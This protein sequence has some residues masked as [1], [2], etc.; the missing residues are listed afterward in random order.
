MEREKHLLSPSS[1]SHKCY[2]IV[3]LRFGIKLPTVKEIPSFLPSS[4]EIKPKQF[5][6]PHS[7]ALSVNIYQLCSTIPSTSGGEEE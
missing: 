2:L 4:K 1:S 5:G 6:F 7:E 3:Q